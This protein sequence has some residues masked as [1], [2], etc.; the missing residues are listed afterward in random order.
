MDSETPQQRI[1][2]LLKE[3]RRFLESDDGAG[4]K[5]R[6]QAGKILWMRLAN[7]VNEF[8]YSRIH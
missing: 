3:V 2:Q 5:L 6:I 1:E 4:G 7:A 8:S